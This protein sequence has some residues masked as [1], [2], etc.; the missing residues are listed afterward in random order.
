[1][2][3]PPSLLL[4][5]SG[6]EL[7]VIVF[8][9]I[10]LTG[11]AWFVL[12]GLTA[13]YWIGPRYIDDVR[14]VAAVCIGLATLGLAAVLAIK[15]ATGIPRPAM[16]PV[17]PAELPSLLGSFVGGEIESDGFSFPSGHATAATVVYGGL[18]LL[19]SVG[20][21][22]L[23][24]L[25]AG[26]C[27]ALI[28]LSR[29]VLQVHYP[30]DVIAGIGLGSVLVA[31][32]VAVGRSEDRFRPDRL[33][34]VAGVVAVIGFGVAVEAGHPREIQQAAI[35]IGTAIGAAAVWYRLGDRLTAAPPVSTPVAIGGL[36]VAGGLW[37]GAY[38][39]LVS[40]VGAVPTSAL[41]VSVIL[42]LPL[43]AEQRQKR[44]T[45]VA[46]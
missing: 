12:V 35:G 11:D 22:R 36:V 27:I 41:A 18:G 46:A 1:M 34:A 21:R 13:L 28:S 4:A 14:P 39:G 2:V 32:G 42:T 19:L 33:F 16:T 37:I 43:I 10:T 30:R 24:Y 45:R 40:T 31:T 20:R 44:K 8:A 15:T 9:L 29:V 6:S 38:A 7:L 3:I 26:S 23:R 25:V 5:V 17:D